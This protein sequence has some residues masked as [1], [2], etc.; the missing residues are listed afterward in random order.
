MNLALRLTNIWDAKLLLFSY[1][2]VLSIQ[3]N[4]LIEVVLLSAFNFGCK[5]VIIF[6]SLSLNICFGA[7]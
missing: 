7:H 2:S 3:K 1:P 4:R 6:L 5:I